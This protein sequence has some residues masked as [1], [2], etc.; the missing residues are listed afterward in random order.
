MPISPAPL[1]PTT[2]LEPR[3]TAP[4]GPITQRGRRPA[5]LGRITE[6]GPR[7]GPL[8]WLERTPALLATAA[9]GH[10]PKPQTIR[11]RPPQP[12]AAIPLEAR[13]ALLERGAGPRGPAVLRVAPLAVQEAQAAVPEAREPLAGA[14]LPQEAVLPAVE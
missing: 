13:A 8:G 3:T 12:V 9:S 2:E 10:L 14:A 6:L 5:P 7:P 1:G 11:T 4:P